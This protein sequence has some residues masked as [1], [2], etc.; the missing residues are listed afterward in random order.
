MSAQPAV[1]R[2]EGIDETLLDAVR[3]IAREAGRA[4]NLIERAFRAGDAGVL[5][6]Q[7]KTD[8][9]PLTA[10]DLAAHRVI[11]AGLA[12][13]RPQW[14]VVSEEGA[15]QPFAVRKDWTR[16]WLVDPLDGT[17]EFLSG[18]GEYTVNIALI[19]HGAPRLG[20]VHAPA[21][22]LEYSG[23]AGRGAW[24]ARAA[25]P[26]ETIRVAGRVPGGDRLR[27]VG[28]RSHRGDSL[29]A[30]L[31]RIGPHDF[32]AMGSSLKFC[33]LAEGAADVYPRLGPTSEWDTAAGHAV[34]LG[35]GGRVMQVDGT[36]LRYNRHEGWLNPD[37]IACG[38]AAADWAQWLRTHRP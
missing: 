27:L 8:D 6:L 10:A 31:A 35:A 24:R 14:P 25:A 30:L 33:V 13:L 36:A 21:T 38:D 19:E 4:I 20:V 29:D 32:V 12:A 5:G 7:T 17:R 37:F 11:A 2:G 18:N 9:S 26:P 15:Q 3:E 1:D 22:G 28:S 16:F 23:L 34:L